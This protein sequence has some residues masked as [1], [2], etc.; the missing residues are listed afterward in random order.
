[1]P[2]RDITASTWWCPTDKPSPRV[3]SSVNVPGA[4]C[5][6]RSGVHECVFSPRSAR[7][8]RGG[9][10]LIP[11]PCRSG[12]VSPAVDS[13]V[14]DLEIV[15]DFR[16]RPSRGDQIEDLTTELLGVSLRHVP[17][18]LDKI[19]ARSQVHRLRQTEDTSPAPRNLA[20]ITLDSPVLFTP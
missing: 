12:P 17:A 18:S 16:D 2:A 4:V 13:L 1:M 7:T 10:V 15:C 9:R 19:V 11:A 5:A 20:H 3:S 8:V 14:A 6:L